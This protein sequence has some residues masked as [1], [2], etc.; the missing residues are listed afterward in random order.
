MCLTADGAAV[1]AD[2]P[3]V[4]TG[5]GVRAAPLPVEGGTGDDVAGA[6]LGGL[7]ATAASNASLHA[8]W[9][10]SAPKGPRVPGGRS[11][12]AGGDIRLARSPWVCAGKLTQLDAA[13]GTGAGTGRP[14]RVAFWRN[15]CGRRDKP[16]TTDDDAPGS[17]AA[18]AGDGAAALA[19]GAAAA[20][21]LLPNS[22]EG[23]TKNFIL[24]RQCNASRPLPP[25]RP[26]ACASGACVHAAVPSAHGRH[27]VSG[28][29]CHCV[30]TSFRRRLPGRRYASPSLPGTRSAR[31][32]LRHAALHAHSRKSDHVFEAAPTERPACGLAALHACPAAGMGSR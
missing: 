29:T 6:A 3:A 20:V 21:G 28:P 11:A 7:R 25:L 9:R 16:S 30:A 22:L 12:V 18:G 2:A 15:S 26:S 4:A 31:L 23:C 14:D 10:S 27:P 8:A 19:G 5:G 13:V 17:C 1:V 24:A 32:R